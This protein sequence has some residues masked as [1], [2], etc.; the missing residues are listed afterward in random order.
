[1]RGLIGLL[2]EQVTDLARLYATSARQEVEE[3][4]NQLKI[5]AVLFGVMVALLAVAIMVLVL[6]LVSAISAASGLPLWA[7][8]LLVLT[9]VLVLA[10]VLGWLGYRRVQKA[11]L[12]PDET[13]AAA[14]EDLEW[15]QHLTKR[16]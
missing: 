9:V 12:M 6:L 10:T 13:I 3:G 15:V 14:K 7:T 4:L 1:M 11:R 8:A 5:A 16:D 2:I